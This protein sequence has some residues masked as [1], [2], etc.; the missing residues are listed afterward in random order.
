MKTKI[1]L[2]IIIILMSMTTYGQNVDMERMDRD[3]EVA[4]NVIESLLGQDNSYFMWSRNIDASYLEGYGVIFTLP[5]DF[6]YSV[7]SGRAV[8]VSS[9]RRAE[10]DYRRSEAAVLA[11]E[12]AKEKADQAEAM[13]K[14]A[15]EAGEKT[16]EAIT[17]FLVDYSDLIGQLNPTEKI[18]VHS[19]AQD[20]FLISIV[21]EGS[22][23]W[24]IEEEGGTSSFSAEIERKDVSEYKQG[25][26]TREEAIK[27][28]EFTESKP[29]EKEQDLELFASIVRRLYSPDL[30]KTFFTEKEPRYERLNG[31]GVIFYMNTYSSYE[32]DR[33]YSMPVLG[34][35]DV[36]ADERKKT[37]EELYPVFEE[38]LK[39]VLVEYG[40]T[41]KSVDDD[42]V[43]MMKIKSTRCKDCSIPES[44]ELTV[45]KSILSQFDQR[46]ISLDEAKR[47]VKIQR[48]K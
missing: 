14:A 9:Y 41:I 12:D 48:Q 35:D 26:I 36:D 10:A 11:E 4:K 3:L 45:K 42:E 39:E 32:N 19:K 25:K 6:V 22:S 16:K 43:I 37:I 24:S 13:E 15:T 17:N 21:G 27:R 20:D 8:G 23:T 30:S 29:A 2:L 33:L 40:R 34:R 5:N 1:S 46:K 38:E 44:L 28:I 31:F 7:G 47:S 18:M